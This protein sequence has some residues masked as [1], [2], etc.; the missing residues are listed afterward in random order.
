MQLLVQTGLRIGEVSTLRLADIELRE[1]TGMVRV[2]DG[3]GR[4][5]REVPLNATARRALRQYLA[6]RPTAGPECALFLSGRNAALPIRSIQAIIAR[7]AQRAHLE[8]LPVSAHRLRH[9]FALE[10]TCAPIRESWSNW[11]ACSVTTRSTPTAIYTR[12]SQADL[13]ADL[14]RS[15]LNVDR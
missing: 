6:Q 2:R 12:P 9:T 3:K 11:P 5:E 13:V 4:K 15:P 1:R 10:L 14:E 8:R 7:L